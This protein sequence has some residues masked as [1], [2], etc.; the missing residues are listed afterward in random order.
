MD[1]LYGTRVSII[2]DALSENSGVAARSRD[3][4]FIQQV[5]SLRGYAALAVVFL[6]SIQGFM[7]LSSPLQGRALLEHVGT[8]YFTFGLIWESIFNGRQAV[9]LFFMLSAFVMGLHIDT[10]KTLTTRTTAQ[11]LVRRAFRLL[12]A[13]WASIVFAM[14][15]GYLFTHGRYSPDLILHYL[16]L[17][18]TSIN[19]PLWSMIVEVEI[20]LCY[21]PFLLFV[22]RLSPLWQIA[23]F[24]AV[25][26]LMKH[27]SL[28]IGWGS[29][30]YTFPL[31]Y[32]YLGL[33]I[34]TLGRAS[35][36]ALSILRM[37]T[38]AFFLAL[39]VSLCL[40]PLTTLADM[41]VTPFGFDLYRSAV[42][43]GT[44]LSIWIVPLATFYVISWV[45]YG[46]NSMSDRL[47]NHR[48][49][50]F[51]GRTSFSIYLF[52]LPMLVT[53]TKVIE[54]TAMPPLLRLLLGLSIVLPATLV[55]ASLSYRYIELPSIGMGRALSRLLSP[56][57]P[58]GRATKAEAALPAE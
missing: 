7:Y 18:N 22:S 19:G 36:E 9:L 37:S 2:R 31:S 30:S 14:A 54:F 29:F 39:P 47:F 5:E 4:G 17:R 6:H 50:I 27:Y 49:S 52:H 56:A 57:E 40:F 53:L 44:D 51:V 28:S 25:V 16:T 45:A 11:F 3:K 15:L 43:W 10:T 8:G 20:S 42:S 21:L 23:G 55:I 38:P 26:W 12:P 33:L 13:V 58:A 41:R 32:V 34:P 48:A 24:Y 35:V 1:Q 46:R